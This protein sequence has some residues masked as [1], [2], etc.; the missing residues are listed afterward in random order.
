MKFKIY[1]EVKLG[2]VGYCHGISLWQIGIHIHI[3]SHVVRVISNGSNE[4]STPLNHSIR[5]NKDMKNSRQ[6]MYEILYLLK[7]K[8]TNNLDGVT[9]CSQSAV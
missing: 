8:C 9:N 1:H 2:R 5:D 6:I 7:V 4:E 3:L